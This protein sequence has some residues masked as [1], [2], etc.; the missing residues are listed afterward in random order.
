MAQCT[1]QEQRPT[2]RDRLSASYNLESVCTMHPEWPRADVHSDVATPFIHSCPCIG[3]HC[4]LHS[5]THITW[6][7]CACHTIMLY[8]SCLATITESDTITLCYEVEVT[9]FNKWY[10]NKHIAFSEI[11]ETI[12]FISW[13]LSNNIKVLFLSFRS[14]YLSVCLENGKNGL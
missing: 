14:L 13:N 2:D 12:L 8:L 11:F 1:H 7:T 5:P 10:S 3:P 9:S 4:Y 6:L